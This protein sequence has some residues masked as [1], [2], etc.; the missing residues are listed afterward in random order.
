VFRYYLLGDRVTKGLLHPH[1]PLP[2]MHL[3]SWRYVPVVPVDPP[4]DPP[5]DGGKKGK[6]ANQVQARGADP[7][8]R[9]GRRMLK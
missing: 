4:I 5:E 8:G 7:P 3:S 9:D 2:D 6:G 1:S